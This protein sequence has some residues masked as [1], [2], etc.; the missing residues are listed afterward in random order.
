[1]AD[2]QYYE[3]VLKAQKPSAGFKLKA[4]MIGIYVLL[5]TLWLIIIVRVGLTA[6]L[7]M[8]IP[9][10]VVT[11]VILTWKYTSVEYEYSFTSGI[12]TFSKIYSSSK[13]KA[14]FET[15]IK[16]LTSAQPYSESTAA[17]IRADEAINAIPAGDGVTPYICIFEENDKTAAV[18]LDMDEMT[19]RIFKFF[20]PSVY[21]SFN[22]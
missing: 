2:I 19:A 5:L 1:M 12:F 8:L 4:M 3:R 13:R 6:S 9:L 16:F 18:I 22:K 20:K 11:V 17:G 7:L 10:S 15:E 14:V 21:F